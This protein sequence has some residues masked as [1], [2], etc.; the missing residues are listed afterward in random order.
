[1][2]VPDTITNY[3]RAHDVSFQLVEHA[4]TRY[5][6]ET[7]QVAHV[8]GDRLAKAIVLADG[9][10]Y[11][12]AVVPATRRV[13][14][15]AVADLMQCRLGLAEEEDFPMLFRDCRPGAVPALGEAYGVETI[16]DD[17]IAEA[18]DVFVESGDHEH[19]I[20]LTHDQFVALTA[21]AWHGHISTA[22]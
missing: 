9:E 2:A 10:R 18:P 15:E 11:F 20:H 1:M 3:L 21:H 12:L 14:T 8:P 4:A 13:D 17:A 7:A 16:V 6:N 22:A 19:L 5:S